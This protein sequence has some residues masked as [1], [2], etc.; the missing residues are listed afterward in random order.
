[1]ICVAADD[2]PAMLADLAADPRVP[3]AARVGTVC[4][5]DAG[6]SGAKATEGDA[7]APRLRVHW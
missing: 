1:M 6:G 5:Y 2:A 4:A 7:A 3:V